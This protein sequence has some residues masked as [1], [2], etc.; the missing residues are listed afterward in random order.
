MHAG[1]F[2]Y[3]SVISIIWS[4]GAALHQHRHD[5]KNHGLPLGSSR[6]IWLSYDNGS[7]LQVGGQG[8]LRRDKLRALS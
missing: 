1:R 8:L 3:T 5:T 4:S 7:I 6:K 2:T